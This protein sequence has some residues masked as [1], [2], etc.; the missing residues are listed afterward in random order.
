MMALSHREAERL[1]IQPGGGPPWANRSPETTRRM[2][3]TFE[4][5]ARDACELILEGSLTKA[6]ATSILRALAYGKV[7]EA[8][9]NI[10]T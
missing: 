6:T 10:H 4:V 8:C 2:E 1:R 3:D 9:I 5:A 7:Q